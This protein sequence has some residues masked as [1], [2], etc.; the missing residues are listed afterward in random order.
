MFP[1]NAWQSAENKEK[2]YLETHDHLCD[3]NNV[4]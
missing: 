3:V 1:M 2:A 4:W